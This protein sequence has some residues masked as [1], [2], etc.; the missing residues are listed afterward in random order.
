MTKLLGIDIGTSS[1]KAALIDA[2]TR[3]I[4]TSAAQEYAIHRP[5][6]DRAEQNPSE[7]WGAVQY[8]VR[9]IT[10]NHTDIAGVGFSGQMHG[11]V[12]LDDAGE[13]VHPAIIWADSRS[14]EQVSQLASAVD[15]L[16]ATTGTLPAVGF[17]GVTLMWLA[18]HAPDALTR[19]HRAILPKDYIHY[20]LTG[21]MTTEV[22][23]AA[24]TGVFDVQRGA[25]ADDIIA[26]VN[27]PRGLFP[28][29]LASHE[30]RPLTD[31]AA[32]ALGLPA[33]I[34]VVAGCADQPA[35]A[36]ANG[37]VA[38]GVVSVTVG[39]GGQV[40][41]P[42][43]NF[44]TDARL[45]VFNHA[46]PGVYYALG[47]TLS[48]GLS[49]RWLRDTLGMT[50]QPDAYA[51]LSAAAADVPPGADGLVFLP[52]LTGERT[53]HMD[54]HA[55]GGFIGLSSYHTRG[56]LARAVMEGVAFSLRQALEITQELGGTVE[57]VIGS[58]G[59]VESSVWRGILTDV[60]G[61]PVRKSLAKEQASVGAALLAGIGAGVY[62]DFAGAAQTDYDAPTVPDDK[63]AAFY[64]GRYAQFK[65]LYPKLVTD[66]H[67]LSGSG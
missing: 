10:A 7:W 50:N 36:L 43:A 58:G 35:Q 40:F 27:L 66:M 67:T 45:H 52:Y 12:L 62:P 59:G 57:T 41:A 8:A 47:A 39:S 16:A 55:R 46:V 2:D 49:L 64:D 42:L 63:R 13:V 48:A 18:Q 24:S 65:A 33:G 5:A 25:W 17:M 54:P 23:D 44:R 14:S 51:D 9:Q 30:P 61:V 4:I 6:P 21:E 26:A 19:A 38:P 53:P 11:T 22:T 60:F 34:P 37:I 3:Q 32:A 31:A 1:A 56:H 29:V 28:D 20:R 15:N